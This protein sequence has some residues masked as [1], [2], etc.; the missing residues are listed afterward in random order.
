[1]FRVKKK[2]QKRGKLQKNKGSDNWHLTL[3]YRGTPEAIRTPDPQ[4]RR[5]L[6][7]PAE[8]RAHE[9]FFLLDDLFSFVKSFFVKN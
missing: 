8:L 7:Y 5:L 3:L 9:H 2:L 1:M 4:L 6:L